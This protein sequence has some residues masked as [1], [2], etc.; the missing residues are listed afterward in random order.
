MGQIQKPARP[1]RSEVTLQGLTRSARTTAAR[2]GDLAVRGPQGAREGVRRRGARARAAAEIDGP[3]D[4][5]ARR[6]ATASSTSAPRTSTARRRTSSRHAQGRRRRVRLPRSRLVPRDPHHD[7]AQGARRRADHRDRLRRLRAGRR[8]VVPVRDRDRQPRAARATTRISVERAEANVAVDDAWF[9]L[10]A[11]QDPVARGDRR[12]PGR[13]RTPAPSR[14]AGTDRRAPVFDAGSDLRPRRAQHRLGRDERTHRRA[15]RAPDEGRQDAALRRR[16]SGGVWKSHRRR[17][18]LQAGVRQ[19]AGAV[20]RRDRDRPDETTKPSGSAPASRGR[21]TR[22]RSAT[23]STSP[24]T[25]ARRGPTWACR[26]P[27]ASS[28][29]VVDPTGQQHGLRLRAGQAVERLGRPRPVQD[30]P[31]AARRGR[32]CCKGRNLSTGCSSL[33]MDPKNPDVLFAGMWDF[34]RKGWTFRSGGDRTRR[35]ER[36]AACSAPTDGGKSWTRDHRPGEQG[37]P[38]EAVRP[39]RGGGRAVE[40]EDRLRVGRVARIRRCTAPTTAARPGSSATRAR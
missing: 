35:A 7:G 15:R 9:T 17:H 31:T 21:A 14:A 18:D 39:H 25:A 26:I 13:R 5:L 28:K 8:R 24:P 4:R 37:L 38:G 32:W 20:D 40:S 36:A 11:G 10:P 1:V 19:A 27:S 30:Q 29:I 6:R 3:L 12:R 33:A 2:L 22:C 34:R 16:R 23:A